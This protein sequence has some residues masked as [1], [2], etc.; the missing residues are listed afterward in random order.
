MCN[1]VQNFEFNVVD[2]LQFT[3]VDLGVVPF[4]DM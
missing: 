1:P 3:D 4:L 2:N